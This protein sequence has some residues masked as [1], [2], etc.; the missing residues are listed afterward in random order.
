VEENVWAG[1]SGGVVESEEDEGAGLV[2]YV[3]RESGIEGLG[4]SRSSC[5]AWGTGSLVMGLR[6][7]RM[8][9]A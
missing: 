4:K 7:R 6:L 3:S 1:V 8:L 9:S 2:V 5:E